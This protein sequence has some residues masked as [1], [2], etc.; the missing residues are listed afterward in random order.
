MVPILAPQPKTPSQPSPYLP[1]ARA[2]TVRAPAK[3]L[4]PSPVPPL[5]HWLWLK[6]SRST[7]STLFGV[8]T[9][10][11]ATDTEEDTVRHLENYTGLL[12]GLQNLVATMASGYEAATKD[13]QALVASTLDVATQHDCTFVAGASQA[14]ANWTEKYQQA[15]SQGENQSL[16][17]QLTHWD[18]VRKARITLSQKITSLTT[19]SEPRTVSSKIFRTLL[20]DCFRR[21]RA[22]T[23]ATF[24]KLNANFPP[25]SASLSLP[26]KLHRCYLPSSSVCTTTIPRAVGWPWPRP[27]SR[28]TPFPTPGPAISLGGYMPDHPRYSSH[29]W[30]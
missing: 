16:H 9:L 30:K 14:L 7:Q 26:I 29:Q 17:N 23:E 19:D 6:R 5:S 22:Q 13:I 27:W 25:C 8:A 21:I 15:M 11:Q 12:T 1:R 3:P 2:P 18:Q 24:N 20:P 4:P 28:S 10:A